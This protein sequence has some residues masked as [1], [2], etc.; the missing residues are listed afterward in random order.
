MAL[1]AKCCRNEQDRVPTILKNIENFRLPLFFPAQVVAGLLLQL[2]APSSRYSSSL[3][4]KRSF[5]PEGSRICILWRS[6]IVYFTFSGI[7]YLNWC[8]LPPP[9]AFCV[10]LVLILRGLSAQSSSWSPQP[11]S[12]SLTW[13]NRTG[14]ALNSSCI[15]HWLGVVRQVNGLSEPLFPRRVGKILVLTSETSTQSDRT[16]KH[17][18]Q[19]RACKYL[20]HGRYAHHY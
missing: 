4:G 16:C 20:G 2:W 17:L 10:Q 8:L 13:D 19:S 6:R 1:N 11:V 15:A 9:Q 14:L 12:I 5:S 3:E 7:S 18:T